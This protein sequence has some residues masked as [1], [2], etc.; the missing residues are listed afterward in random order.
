MTDE[1]LVPID[2]RV[3]RQWQIE[4]ILGTV[5]LTIGVVILGVVLPVPTV[6]G[7][8]GAIA[9]GL[10]FIVGGLALV[11]VRY[12]H[13]RYALGDDVLVLQHGVWQRRLSMTP[14][15]RVQN[16]D[17]IDGPHERRLGLKRLTI[18]TASAATDASIPG[19]D[20]DEADRLRTRILER[21]GRDAAV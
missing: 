6:L 20:S 13:W 1:T 7:V 19:L 8:V 4:S 10:V 14:Y 15:F 18:S 3:R 9:I 17:V 5:P 2:A 16:V 12:R 21:A 11:G